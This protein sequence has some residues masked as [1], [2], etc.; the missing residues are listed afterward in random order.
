[1]RACACPV[2]AR[3]RNEGAAFLQF[4]DQQWVGH[5][6]AMSK[7]EASNTKELLA[8]LDLEPLEDNLFRGISLEEGWQRVYGGQVL[9]QALTAAMR[10]VAD[11]R[12]VHSL[13]SYFLL[14]GDPGRP[15]IYEVERLREGGSFSTRRVKAI[16]HGSVIFIMSASF[17]KEEQG[18]DHRNEMPDVPGPETL[19]SASEI[20]AQR[21]NEIP[22]S[23]RNYWSRPQP[24]DMRPVDVGRY[25]D[26]GKRPPQQCIWIR[27][28]AALPDDLRIHQVV[29]AYISDF[30]L[31]DTALIA[32]GKTL[33]DPDVQLASLDHAL[34]FHRPVRA[35][36]W[37]LYAQD[38][39][40][41]SGARGFCRGQV[42]TRDG[43]LVASSAQE[44]L[45]RQR[46]TR[47]S[48]G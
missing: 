1:M 14:A 43:R 36:E 38:S 24:F 21:I 17:H 3:M 4:F 10:T 12:Q 7:D 47:F 19:M 13:H 18:F 23:M 32:H 11:A 22:S 8:I 34:W 29:L 39:P 25:F 5:S 35:D 9:A 42:F 40:S 45:M 48:I 46:S 15:I 16:Q 41:A 30:T 33:F 28:K 6:A 37:L 2:V 20:V 31:L 27:S 26:G 44:G